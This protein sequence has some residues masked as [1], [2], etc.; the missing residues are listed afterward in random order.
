MRRIYAILGLGIVALGVLHMSA[1]FRLDALTSSAIW[2]FSGGVSLVLTGA[3]NLLNRAY[4]ATAPGLRTFCIAT[5]IGMT[6]FSCIGGWVTHAG[7]GELAVVVGWF[8]ATT[9]LSV[10]RGAVGMARETIVGAARG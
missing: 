4:G 8:G 10:T 7:V 6:I 3:L 9:I 2:F 1:T 5:N